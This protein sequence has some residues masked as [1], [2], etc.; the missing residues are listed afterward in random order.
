MLRYHLHLL[1]LVLWLSLLFNLDLVLVDSAYIHVAQ[2]IYVLSVAIAVFGLLF[3]LWWRVSLK[4]VLAIA[5]LSFLL[6]KYYGDRP[7]WG[8]QYT[9]LSLLELAAVLLT[10]TLASAVGQHSIDFLD[11]I[12][13]LIG[14]DMA[15]RIY[16]PAD[17]E[18]MVKRE[19]QY[20]RRVNRPLSVLVVRAVSEGIH[21]NHD[22]TAKEIGRLL[23]KRYSLVALARL[24]ADTLRQTDFVVDQSDKGQLAVIAP[25]TQ[26]DQAM[27]LINRLNELSQERLGAPVRFGMASLSD[28]GNTFEELLFQAER[29]LQF[30][31]VDRRE[32]R[33]AIPQT[34]VV[35]DHY[36]VSST[37]ES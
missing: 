9:Y 20:S 32:K 24:L 26:T 27:A 8:G 21:R 15:G 34:Q 14:S 10:A 1:M 30:V 36:L 35:A 22:A 7:F 16:S 31:M 6:V 28:Q 33:D 4:G 19:M 12:R 37:D 25:D 17:A 2:P 3:P 18:F 5:I 23:A 13:A 29:N 11:T